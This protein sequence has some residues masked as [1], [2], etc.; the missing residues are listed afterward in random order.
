ME[1]KGCESIIHDHN[2]DLWATMVKWVDVPHS[3][4][5]DFRCLC[6]VDIS[7][8]PPYLFMS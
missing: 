7:S 4:W 1:Q 8:Y 3:D 2:R 5:G 6:A